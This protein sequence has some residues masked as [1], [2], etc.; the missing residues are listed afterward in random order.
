ML[1][2]AGRSES[3]FL[4]KNFE[5]L[6]KIFFETAITFEIV[7]Q[8]MTYKY[9]I[10]ASDADLQDEYRFYGDWTCHFC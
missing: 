6:S 3:D 9:A 7:H 8:T 1:G 2:F 10:D 5:K 4:K